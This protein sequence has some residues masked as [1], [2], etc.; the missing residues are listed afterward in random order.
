MYYV[1]RGKILNLLIRAVDTLEKFTLHLL[2]RIVPDYRSAFVLCHHLSSASRTSH[3]LHVSSSPIFRVD[4]IMRR[5]IAFVLSLLTSFCA[6]R[7]NT[8]YLTTPMVPHLQPPQAASPH[9]THIAQLIARVRATDLTSEEC[10]RNAITQAAVPNP[11]ND[12]D[13]RPDTPCLGKTT[14]WGWTFPSG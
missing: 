5:F 10:E 2:F 11:A 8:S 1:R 12:A 4:S 6:S 14:S 13:Y 9:L 7:L 3:P